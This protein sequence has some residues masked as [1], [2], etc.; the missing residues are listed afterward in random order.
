MH[1]NSLAIFCFLTGFLPAFKM[2]YYKTKTVDKQ[3]KSVPFDRLYQQCLD[4]ENFALATKQQEFEQKRDYLLGQL[5]QQLGSAEASYEGNA[6]ETLNLQ[7]P[8]WSE[9]KRQARQKYIVEE[10]I[11]QYKLDVTMQ[12]WYLEQVI[13]YIVGDASDKFNLPKNWMEPY[14]FV[15]AEGQINCREALNQIFDFKSE[16]DRGLYWFLMLDSRSSYLKTQ[17]KG[18]ARQWCSLVPLILYP[19]KLLYNVPYSRW[20]REDLHLV[21]NKSLCDAMLCDIPEVSKERL[22][23]IR[24]Q[25]MMYRSGTKAGEMRNPIS[26]YKLYGVQSTDIGH[27]PELAQTMLTQIWCAHPQNRTKYMVLDPKNWDWIPDP[28]LSAQSIF[29]QETYKQS[30]TPKV[31]EDLPWL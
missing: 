5:E 21:V 16:W 3:L 19:F 25:G 4:A 9:I 18:E 29:Q 31:T 22:L 13:K 11:P 7:E 26:T 24:E 2:N 28:L 30:A 17:Y 20:R 8:D 1:L 6:S 12:Q 27:L 10:F 15:T 23:E 14:K